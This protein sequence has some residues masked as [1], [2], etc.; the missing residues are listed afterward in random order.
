MKP[1]GCES[2]IYIRRLHHK[3]LLHM[4]NKTPKLYIF[5]IKRK[6]VE[7]LPAV[8]WVVNH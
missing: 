1:D 4:L 6:S 2:A 8:Q 5:I 3:R 7:T